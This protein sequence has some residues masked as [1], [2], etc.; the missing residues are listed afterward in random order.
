MAVDEK[1][2]DRIL[3]LKK[4]ENMIPAL[5]AIAVTALAFYDSNLNHELLWVMYGLLAFVWTVLLT[6]I[7]MY[8]SYVVL[9]A[10]FLLSAELSLLIFLAQEYC[11]TGVHTGDAALRALVLLAVLYILFEFFRSL[12]KA[13][14]EEREKI[15]N[16]KT[17][18]IGWVVIGLFLLSVIGLLWIIYQVVSPIILGLCAFQV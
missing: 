18:K 4:R 11:N 14:R 17:P 9:K 1:L 6:V 5:L 15:S 12:G 16:K 13:L 2:K 7:L 8:A 10:F 3:E